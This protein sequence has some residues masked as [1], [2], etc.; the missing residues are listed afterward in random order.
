M[1]ITN[2]SNLDTIFNNKTLMITGGTG[3]FVCT[4]TF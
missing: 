3:S 4:L 1:T 2:E